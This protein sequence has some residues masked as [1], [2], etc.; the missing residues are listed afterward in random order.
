MLE[1]QE[2]AYLPEGTAWGCQGTDGASDY[3]DVEEKEMEK[4]EARGEGLIL[5]SGQR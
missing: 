2:K 3:D 4:E 5:Q 1:A